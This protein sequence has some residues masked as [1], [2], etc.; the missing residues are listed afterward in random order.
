MLPML[1]PIAF[2]SVAPGRVRILL[3]RTVLRG[4]LARRGHL[5]LGLLRPGGL[6]PA[7]ADLAE[8][9]LGPAGVA[10]A[11][12]EL[13]VAERDLGLLVGDQVEVVVEL[14]GQLGLRGRGR[15]SCVWR[16]SAWAFS[17]PAESYSGPR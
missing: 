14:V 13:A 7:G 15:W 5:D 2:G 4:A 8:V 1:L 12:V 17:R 6:R 16:I 10:G 9:V 3:G 11:L